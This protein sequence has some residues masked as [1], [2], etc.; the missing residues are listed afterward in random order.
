MPHKLAKTAL[1]I[2]LLG[3]ASTFAEVRAATLTLFTME[4]GARDQCPND[5]IAWLIH[6]TKTYHLE[7]CGDPL[8]HNHVKANGAYVCRNEVEKWPGVHLDRHR[9]ACRLH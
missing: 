4:Q 9:P 6:K 3:G 7:K 2:F 8:F 5:K 1:A